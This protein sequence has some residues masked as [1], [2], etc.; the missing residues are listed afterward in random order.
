VQR[1]TFRPYLN[2]VD[3][4]VKRELCCPGY[5][6]YVDDMLLFGGDKRQLWD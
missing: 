2:P 3:H 1:T 4:F 5:V 6:R